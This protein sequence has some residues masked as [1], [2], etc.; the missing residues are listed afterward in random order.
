MK[1][2]KKTDKRNAEIIIIINYNVCQWFASV[3][4]SDMVGQLIII[5]C[6]NLYKNTC[7]D[8]QISYLQ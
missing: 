6:Y 7:I 8:P 1:K 4:F 3:W 2:E 5:S